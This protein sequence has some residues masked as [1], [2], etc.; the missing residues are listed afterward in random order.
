MMEI[1]LYYSMAIVE[2]YKKKTQTTYSISAYEQAQIYARNNKQLIYGRKSN[3]DSISIGAI[4]VVAS[5][6]AH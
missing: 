6:A 3:N 1:N 4:V 2:K 5:V